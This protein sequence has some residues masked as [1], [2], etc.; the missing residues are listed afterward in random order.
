MMC[1]PSHCLV[2]MLTNVVAQVGG[3]DSYKPE[4]WR[5]ALEAALHPKR[6]ASNALCGGGHSNVPC[7]YIHMGEQ[8]MSKESR[9]AFALRW[10]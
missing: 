5:S 10:I 2:I 9:N 8:D 3:P 7:L 6:A 4:I 1:C